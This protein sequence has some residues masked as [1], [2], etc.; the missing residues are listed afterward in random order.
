MNTLS[1]HPLKITACLWFNDNAEEAVNFYV[2]LFDNSSI[3]KPTY[4]GKNSPMPEGSI[5]TIPFVI[6]GREYIAL[7][8]GPAFT[9]NESISLVIHCHTQEE[10]DRY[11]NI[12]SEGGIIQQCG[13]L[14]DKYGLSWQIVPSELGL[15]LQHENS[16]KTDRVMQA[17]L[18]MVKIDLQTLK[19][20]FEG[21]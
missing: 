4:Y 10:I 18:N 14:K 9:F 3:G 8:G 7:N 20:A 6:A 21:N 17:V 15:M 13:W 12:L 16:D 2:S 5:L 11:W 19:D 1:S